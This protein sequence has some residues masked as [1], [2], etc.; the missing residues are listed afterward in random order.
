MKK[1]VLAICVG[2]CIAA[3][4]ICTVNQTEDALAN[5]VIRLHIRA[6][7][8]SEEDQALKLKVRDRLLSESKKMMK[9][10]MSIDEVRSYARENLAVIRAIAVDEIRKNGYDYDVNV[11]YGK[12]EFP[13]KTYGD[14]TLP[15]GTYEALVVEIGASE[16]ENW[17]CV[18]F[19]P[20]C[21]VDEAC[22]GPEAPEM[23]IESLG[24]DT[25]DMV[26]NDKIQIKF[27]VYELI[28]DIW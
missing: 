4:V 12:S 13:V 21:F 27:K 1:L 19:P 8:N 7:S 11:N 9:N 5:G 10:D 20:L 22:V 24:E 14:M 25:Y 18:M 2:F 6:N 26:S 23:L 3:S 15:A 17:W 28:R 16:G